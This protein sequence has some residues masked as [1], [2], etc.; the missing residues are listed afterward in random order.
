MVRPMLVAGLTAILIVAGLSSPA[1]TVSSTDQA[2]AEGSS[3]VAIFETSHKK[4]AF[5]LQQWADSNGSDFS[6]HIFTRTPRS[7]FGMSYGTPMEYAYRNRKRQ[8]MPL[9]FWRESTTSS[10]TTELVPQFDFEGASGMT[11]LLPRGKARAGTYTILLEDDY[12]KPAQWDCSIY[13]KEV[14]NW[15]EDF[16]Y[17]GWKAFQFTI[18]NQRVSSFRV[19]SGKAYNSKKYRKQIKKVLPG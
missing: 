13:Y 9:Q 18:E 11:L 8:K 5:T 15:R 6:F 2:A 14:C 3:A 4:Q 19:K 10:S 16:Q 1:H 17:Y 7:L 12:F